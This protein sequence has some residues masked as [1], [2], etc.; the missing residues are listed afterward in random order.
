MK[1]I[2]TAG[3]LRP[4]DNEFVG[5][6]GDDGLLEKVVGLVAGGG[7]MSWG[8]FSL[9]AESLSMAGMRSWPP[10]ALPAG[11]KAEV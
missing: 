8:T 2:D 9:K 1:E 10:L 3:G 6:D 7:C 5:G 11:C 4:V